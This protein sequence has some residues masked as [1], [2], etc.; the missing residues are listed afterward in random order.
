[1]ALTGTAGLATR[2]M[3]SLSGGERQLVFI[4]AALAQGGRV[5][6]LDEP[7]TFLDARH[8]AEVVELMHRLHRGRAQAVVAATHDLNTTAAA[9]DMVL[10]LREGRSVFWG[11]PGELLEPR[12]LEEIFATEF[13]LVRTPERALPLALPRRRM[14][15]S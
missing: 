9:A 11:P 6:L 5:L 1:M 12:L 4:A 15:A 14:E 13:E 8:Q 10:A 7:T 2:D 3:R